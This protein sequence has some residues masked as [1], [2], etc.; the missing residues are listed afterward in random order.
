MNMQIN[1]FHFTSSAAAHEDVSCFT[2]TSLLCIT[3]ALKNKKNYNLHP[4]KLDQ[5]SPDIR[6]RFTPALSG[7]DELMYEFLARDQR[8]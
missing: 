6:L 3:G 5:R 7:H 4:L 8:R 2:V 1:P